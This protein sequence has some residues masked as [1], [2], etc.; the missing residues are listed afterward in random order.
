MMPALDAWLAKAAKCG[1]MRQCRRDDPHI[2]RHLAKWVNDANLDF[3]SVGLGT[4]AGFVGDHFDGSIH[5]ILYVAV[6]PGQY[7]PGKWEHQKERLLKYCRCGRASDIFAWE[8]NT[9]WATMRNAKW[10]ALYEGAG[11]S[12]WK[13]V[14][15][16]N[17]CL[18]PTQNDRT[19]EAGVI[20]R[21]VET[22]LIPLVDILRPTL[23]LF[24]SMSNQEDI[25]EEARRGLDQR[26][27]AHETVP[28]PARRGHGQTAENIK[29]AVRDAVGRKKVAKRLASHRR[30][31]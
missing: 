30:N 27:I 7:N 9:I 25:F 16:T 31:V 12:G 3:P 23:V 13:D 29:W 1:N 17:V 14:A 24:L 2:E 26:C 8:T 5:K 28:H 11:L 6:N 15:F 19:P 20:R 10:R 22:H 4:Y 18:C 21:C